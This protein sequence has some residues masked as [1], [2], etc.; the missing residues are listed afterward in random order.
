MERLKK[1]VPLQRFKKAIDCFTKF[2]KNKMKKLVFM[3]A[4][5]AAISF[6]SCGN[7]T[8]EAPA[9]DSVADSAVVDST[10]SVSADSA[11]VDSTATDSAAQA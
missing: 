6:A 11:V 9:E 1:S 4:A 2:L 8:T 7:K 5:F 3:F 10:D